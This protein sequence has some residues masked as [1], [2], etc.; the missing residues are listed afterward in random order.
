[1]KNMVNL[2]VSLPLYTTAFF[3]AAIPI[4]ITTKNEKK[5]T[6]EIAKIKPRQVVF[7]DSSFATDQDKVNFEERLKRL[8]AGTKFN[9]L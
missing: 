3:A 5:N 2:N 8:S 4:V 1:M 9:V 6:E 7:R